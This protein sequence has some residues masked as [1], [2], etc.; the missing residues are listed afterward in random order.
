MPD[1]EARLG[2]GAELRRKK[3]EVAHTGLPD[4]RGFL[5]LIVDQISKNAKVAMKTWQIA[6]DG[7]PDGA[8][9]KCEVSMRQHVAHPDGHSPRD[10][11]M[12]SRKVREAFCN[13][14]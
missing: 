2:V 8:Q 7:R 9:V 11:R 10:L 12:F 5:R 14:V 6:V 13:V 3:R 1:T 4:W